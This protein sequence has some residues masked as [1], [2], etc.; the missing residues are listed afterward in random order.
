MFNSQKGISMLVV[1]II[2]ITVFI[3]LAGGFILW[4][5]KNLPEELIASQSPTPSQA[6]NEFSDWETYNNQIHNF[7]IK[8]PKNWTLQKEVGVP[9]STV[10]G[11]RWD[12]NG[13]CSLNL[14]IVEN[15]VDSSA[16]MDWY[17]KNGYKE[18]S[19]NI[20]GMSGTKFSKFPVE[21]SGPVGVIYFKGNS[22]RIDM[23]ASE[24]KR[25]ECTKIFDG[26]ISSF[27]FTESKDET[28]KWKTYEDEKNGVEFKYPENFGANVWRAYSWP[29]KLIV[30]SDTQDPLKAGCPD[31]SPN[32]SNTPVEIN[33][34]DFIFYEAGD[35]AAGST[36]TTY[37][38]ITKKNNNYYVFDFF[39]RTTNGCGTNCGPYCE[40]EFEAE[41]KNL[42]IVN[43]I[44][45]PIEKI[46][47]T[48]KFLK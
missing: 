45:K 34:L 24:D 26:M 29:P 30:V 10:I 8:Y 46:V 14:L 21:N 25:Q 43:A 42:D 11:R 20:A 40:T 1:I 9:P 23:V 22:D 3:I 39:I 6:E 38:Y 41:C 15:N 32:A 4:K 27:K 16:E 37:C 18:E 33:G 44:D 2:I 13:Y 47:S 7:E 5:N 28:V 36:Y 12:D 17:R 48:L 31:L 35:G 19:Y